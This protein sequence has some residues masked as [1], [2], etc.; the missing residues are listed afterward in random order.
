M[1]FLICFLISFNCFAGYM[2]KTDIADCDKVGRKMRHEKSKCVG[3]CVEVPKNYNCET[4]SE[5][6]TQVD[7]LENPNYSKNQINKCG[8][9]C[10]TL[11]P[12]L[13]CNDSEETAILNLDLGQ[14]YCSK[15]TDYDQKTIKMFREDTV[16]KSVYDAAKQVLKEEKDADKVTRSE[17]KS[18]LTTLNQ[19]TDLTPSETRKFRIQVIKKLFK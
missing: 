4:F 9:Y 12:D 6:D 10:E 19:G 8:E 11:F 2:S 7:D 18:L 17:L 5:Q 1:K 15:F 3:D 13:V 14:I 16:K